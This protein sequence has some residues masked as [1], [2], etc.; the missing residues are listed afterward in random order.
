MSSRSVAKAALALLA[1]SQVLSN[2]GQASAQSPEVTQ[3]DGL[4]QEGK[5]LLDANRTAEACE[6]LAQSFRLEPALGALGMLAF[7]HEKQ[8]RLATA[9]RE[10]RKT[11]ELARQAHDA[12][13]E[14]VAR[15]RM[16]ALASRVSTI[17]VDV[18]AP[19]PDL[20]VTIAGDVVVESDWGKPLEV[21]PGEVMIIASAP[22][23][24]SWTK[25]ASLTA[26]RASLIIEVP[27]LP[28]LPLAAIAPSARLYP[29]SQ[30]P[31]PPA[32][33]LAL[34]IIAFGLGAIGI[35]AGAGLGIA[36]WSKNQESNRHCDASNACDPEGG[37]QRD[38]ARTTGTLS[39]IAFGVGVAGLSAGAVLLWYGARPSP[40]TS[41]GR[42]GV[43]PV[44]SAK[45][46][47]V[48][49]GGTF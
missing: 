1:A 29:A 9:L 47:M 20:V 45:S 7:C 36:A 30:A 17:R 27:L 11:A 31:E 19:P 40:A 22:H 34:P 21:D 38:R 37:R 43:E 10:Y 41:T 16:E 14:S 39:N 26:E 5:A 46:A 28:A 48:N 25:V 15:E 33:S 42:I 2:A 49:V 23:H 3:A 35:A 32:R 6:R 8:G 44:I 24:V 18:P 12:T 13:R 4:F